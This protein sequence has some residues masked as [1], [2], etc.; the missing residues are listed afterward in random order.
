MNRL[1]EPLPDG[2]YKITEVS[3]EIH[4][5]EIE[6][7]FPEEGFRLFQYVSY[8]IL[9]QCQIDNTSLPYFNVDDFKAYPRES[10]TLFSFLYH[11]HNLYARSICERVARIKIAQNLKLF[12]QQ[13]L[14]NYGYF[15][16][17][18]IA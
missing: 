4:Y 11:S 9:S 13:R 3:G 1:L 12:L 10:D 16:D 18:R 6:R 17:H 15:Y 7:P 5:S 2:K 14:N 8:P